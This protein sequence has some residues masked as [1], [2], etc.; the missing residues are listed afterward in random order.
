[1]R[2][3][4]VAGNWKMNKNYTEA[5]ELMH[6]LDIYK[7]HNAINCEVYIAPPALYITTAKNIFLIL[8]ALVYYYVLHS[9]WNS[10]QPIHQYRFLKHLK[11]LS[12]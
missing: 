6:E 1:M 5:Q 8:R 3:K 12:F 7:K 2:K 11:H 9:L 10:P 4:I